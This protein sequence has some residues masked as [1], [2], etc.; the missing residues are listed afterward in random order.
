M[1]QLQIGS[2]PLKTS[3]VQFG[4]VKNR[5]EIYQDPSCVP[6]GVSLLLKS[7][8]A[9]EVA[10]EAQWAPGLLYSSEGRRPLT[11]E[12]LPASLLAPQ[13]QDHLSVTRFGLTSWFF[14]VPQCHLNHAATSCPTIVTF[15]QREI[16]CAHWIAPV[17]PQKFLWPEY[18]DSWPSHS[19]DSRQTK[20][21]QGAL[22]KSGRIDTHL[23]QP[24]SIFLCS[25]MEQTF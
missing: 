9:E 23:E 10:Q 18:L 12:F 21:F 2:V 1:Y 14:Y 16:R 11:S 7:Q 24:S 3:R 6:L 13:P 5:T 22:W 8:E 17:A 15:P 25:T 20:Y 19:C 4:F